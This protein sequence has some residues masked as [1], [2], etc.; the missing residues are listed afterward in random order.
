MNRVIAGDYKGQGMMRMGNSVQITLPMFKMV[1]LNRSTVAEYEVLNETMRTSSSSAMGRA[2]LGSF[3]LG[4]AGAAAA[5]GAKQK[6][7]Y[8][9]AIQFKDG[10]RSL[11][12][13]DD[14]YFRAITVA[15]F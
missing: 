1:K 11:L 5:L 14:K 9:I 8:W 15:L 4:P 7:T 2:A 10:K 12:E 6:G 3:F 13:V